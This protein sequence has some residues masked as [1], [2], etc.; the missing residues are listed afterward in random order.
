MPQKVKKYV[1]Q[2]EK[3]S[4]NP[5]QLAMDIEEKLNIS[6]FGRGPYAPIEGFLSTK[7]GEI[8]VSIYQE[9]KLPNFSA[10]HLTPDEEERLAK[11][12]SEHKPY[13]ETH[14]G[15]HARVVSRFSPSIG[16]ILVKN[17]KTGDEKFA[18][19]FLFKQTDWL[20]TAAHVVE[21]DKWVI[22][23]IEFGSTVVSC[24]EVLYYDL[25][26]D[27]ALLRLGKKISSSPVFI[28]QKLNY[29]DDLGMRCAVL[30]YPNIPGMEPS[31]SIYE[32]SIVSQKNNYLMKQNLL[33]MSTHLGS[34]MSGTP[35]LNDNLSL[36]GIVIG[37]PGEEGPWPK[38]TPV[39]LPCNE[40]IAA[41]ESLPAGKSYFH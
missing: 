13:K 1:F 18:T 9:D 20:M 25:Q 6:I 41:D 11:I 37:F 12:I 7:D 8:I 17:Q 15:P 2:K 36:V 40:I 26:K 10:R 3:G 31:P 30:G 33:E 23:Q 29:P 4:F 22:Q 38:W 35:V 14:R 34:G 5:D 21:K 19:G 24:N 32:I 28:R 27:L 39:A 16:R